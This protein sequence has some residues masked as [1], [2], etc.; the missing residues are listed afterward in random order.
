MVVE[1]AAHD[2]LP[3]MLVHGLAEGDN[4]LGGRALDAAHRRLARAD[5]TRELRRALPAI[6]AGDG[7][8]DVLLGQ[9]A[10]GDALR[11]LGSRGSRSRGNGE[12]GAR[13]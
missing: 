11:G 12:A 4:T 6:D 2:A 5:G 8:Q 1:A 7:D 3:S 9:G 13:K 10:R